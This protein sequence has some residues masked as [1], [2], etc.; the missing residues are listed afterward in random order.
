MGE[1]REEPKGTEPHLNQISTLWTVVLQAHA[2]PEGAALEARK[3][4][5]NRYWGAVRRYL[6][7]ALHDDEGADELAQ[8]FALRFVR[9]DFRKVHPERGRFRQY[10]KTVLIH[11][12]HDYHR[13]RRQWPRSLDSDVPEPQVPPPLSTEDGQA[14]LTS[15]REELLGRAW[16]RLAESQP[17]YHTVLRLRVDWPALASAQIAERLRSQMDKEINAAWVR[18]TLQRAHA[19]F[20]ALLVEEVAASLEDASAES[21]RQELQELDLLKYCHAV[22]EK[23]ETDAAEDRP[24]D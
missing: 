12:V 1:D 13:A 23:R 17:S 8:E 3:T 15:W 20:A 4:L 19:K 5:L 18:K 14:F 10:L 9:G 7:G 2:G 16:E 21:L 11:L 24:A 22:L 6:R